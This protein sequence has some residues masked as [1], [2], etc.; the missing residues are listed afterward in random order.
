MFEFT[1]IKELTKAMYQ[2][3]E[4]LIATI[5]FLLLF[6]GVIGYAIYRKFFRR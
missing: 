6:I 3:T 1:L 2:S 4:N 5:F